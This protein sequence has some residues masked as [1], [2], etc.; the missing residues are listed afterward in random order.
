MY[1]FLLVK[2]QHDNSDSSSDNELFFYL[3]HK[4]Y[5]YRKS[6]PQFVKKFLLRL[7]KE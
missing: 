3:N 6:S 2:E 7:L 1:F 5:C 4:R